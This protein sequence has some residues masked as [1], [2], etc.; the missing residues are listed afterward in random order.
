M[1]RR[2]SH[3]AKLDVESGRWWRRRRRWRWRRRRRKHRDGGADRHARSIGVGRPQRHRMLAHGEI[4]SGKGSSRPE[5]AVQVG[6]PLK[7]GARQG[8]VFCVGRGAL[9]RDRSA[10][11]EVGPGL[12]GGDRR[13]RGLVRWRRW[14]GRRSRWRWCRWLRAAARRRSAGLRR[15]A[16]TCADADR[17]EDRHAQRGQGSRN[18]AALEHW[19]TSDVG[20]VQLD[21][22]GVHER[23]PAVRRTLHVERCKG[24]AGGGKGRIAADKIR[25]V[26]VVK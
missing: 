26:A 5:D 10:G 17:Q 16:L 7:R 25:Q 15:P 2:S 8:A 13:A 20:N 6:G 11:L 23:V 21:L 3:V 22:R 9:E 24:V 14:W 19:R 18:R 4:A 1:S 12:R